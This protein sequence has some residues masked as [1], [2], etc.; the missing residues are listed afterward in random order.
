MAL[1]ADWSTDRRASAPISAIGQIRP[2]KYPEWILVFHFEKHL[3]LDYYAPS[4]NL[5]R[6][7]RK[8]SLGLDKDPWLSCI[9]I[10]RLL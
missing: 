2:I 3:F 9:S 10:C 8:I 6:V 1:G 4:R 7:M 5:F